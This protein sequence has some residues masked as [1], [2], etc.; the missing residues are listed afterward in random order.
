MNLKDIMWNKRSQMQKNTC[1]L[2][3]LIGRARR[4]KSNQMVMEATTVISCVRGIVIG[5][6]GNFPESW[7]YSIFCSV[8]GNMVV[9]I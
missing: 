3:P 7:K 5:A 6:C 8:V 1:Y 9:Y 2:V 4:L